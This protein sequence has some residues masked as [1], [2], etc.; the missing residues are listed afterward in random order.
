MHTPISIIELHGGVRKLYRFPNNY[1]A[2]VV[3]PLLSFK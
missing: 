2:S 1:G 3:H